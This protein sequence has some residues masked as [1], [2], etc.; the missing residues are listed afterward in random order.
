MEYKW[1]TFD[2]LES[3]IM[4]IMM[5]RRMLFLKNNIYLKYCSHEQIQVPEEI[6]AFLLA[7]NASTMFPFFI[8]FKQF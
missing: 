7:L 1:Q 4:P 5:D 3:T 6:N 8:N 2:L